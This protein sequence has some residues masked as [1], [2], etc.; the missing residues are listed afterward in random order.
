[1]PWASDSLSRLPHT[2]S[3]FVAWAGITVLGS[4]WMSCTAPDTNSPRS[5]AIVPCTFMPVPALTSALSASNMK[6]PA[7]V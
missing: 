6:F 3:E 4:I 7:R 5:L 2:L 1:V